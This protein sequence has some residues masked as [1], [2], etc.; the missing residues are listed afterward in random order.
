MPR[1]SRGSSRAMSSS[2]S[3]PIPT[4][5]EG[6]DR[7]KTLLMRRTQFEIE[8]RQTV[9]PQL[10][11]AIIALSTEY[12]YDVLHLR[13]VEIV[14][15]VLSF[16][17]RGWTSRALPD[18]ADRNFPRDPV[19]AP[20]DRGVVIDG[21]RKLIPTLPRVHA[22]GRRDSK[23]SDNDRSRKEKERRAGLTRRTV[24]GIAPF[25]PGLGPCPSVARSW[26]NGESS[27]AERPTPS[28]GEAMQHP[29]ADAALSIAVP[30]E[31]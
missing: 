6:L 12:R 1:G 10:P 26:Q 3:K 23:R 21:R 7:P 19:Q 30:L 25:T 31:I 22:E 27:N 13:K 28:Q 5:G 2:P 8:R 11:H 15:D 20:A 18:F 9:C 17:W 29:S 24:D 16:R 4:W 14:K